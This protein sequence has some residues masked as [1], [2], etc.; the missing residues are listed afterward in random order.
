MLAVIRL[1]C[2]RLE[3]P[4]YGSLAMMESSSCRSKL[5]WSSA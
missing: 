4:T 1:S 3:P 5:N 2:G